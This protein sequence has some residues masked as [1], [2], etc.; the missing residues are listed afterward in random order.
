MQWPRTPTSKLFEQGAASEGDE[1]WT[2]EAG[3]QGYPWEVCPSLL[4]GLT[5]CA[6]LAWSGRH[7]HRSRAQ[8]GHG[9]DRR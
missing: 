5:V 8:D 3:M 1:G 6:L 7:V 9:H 4:C 2:E